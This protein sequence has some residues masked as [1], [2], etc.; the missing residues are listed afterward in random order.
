MWLLARILPL[1][2]GDFLDE[3]ED[4]HWQ[5]YL[6]LMD[7][8][9]LIFCPKASHDHAAYVATLIGDHHS[10]FCQLYSGRSIIPKMHYMVH[11]PKLMIK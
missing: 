7:I 5:L 2:V 1:L 3:E 6:Q 9:D 8:I 11:M 10:T 4:Q